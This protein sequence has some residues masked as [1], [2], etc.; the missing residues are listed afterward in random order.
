M[1]KSHREC[2]QEN[3]VKLSQL[4][5]HSLYIFLLFFRRSFEYEIKSLLEQQSQGIDLKDLTEIPFQAQISYELPD[6]SK[7]LRVITKTQKISEDKKEVEKNVRV[8]ILATNAAQRNAELALQGRLA[9]AEENSK[10]WGSYM[11]KDIMSNAEKAEQLAVVEN[12]QK[13]NIAFVSAIQQQKEQKVSGKDAD[14]LTTNMYNM[15][16]I[17]SS[18]WNQQ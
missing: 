7:Y 13:Q 4:L 2:H 16:Q 6:G 11:S 18:Y 3:R 12:F 14:D 5:N 15:K 17:N 9:E 8:D 10:K 1:H